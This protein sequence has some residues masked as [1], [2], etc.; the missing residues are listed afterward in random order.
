MLERHLVGRGRLAAR[1]RTNSSPFETE[2]VVA[3]YKEGKMA[4]A[5]MVGGVESSL[6]RR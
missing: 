1:A 6:K 2:G 4:V 3:V 5:A